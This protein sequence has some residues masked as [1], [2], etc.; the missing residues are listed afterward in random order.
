MINRNYR[1]SS[2]M[3]LIMI[4][5]VHSNANGSADSLL[6]KSQINK[7]ASAFTE[8][9]PASFIE[10]K[11]LSKVHDLI[12]GKAFGNELADSQYQDLGREAQAAVGVL[13][14]YHVPIRKFPKVLSNLPIGAFAMTGAIYVNE[15]QLM[16]ESYG[17]KQCALLC[18][19]VHKKYNDTSFSLMILFGSFMGSSITASYLMRNFNRLTRYPVVAAAALGGMYLATTSYS[20]FAERRADI[21]GHYAAACSRCVEESASRRQLIFGLENNPLKNS[22]CLNAADLEKIA[23]DLRAENKLC[24]HHGGNS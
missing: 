10:N 23:Q 11:I 17:A 15:D 21:E 4:S 7:T 6:E 24:S 14:E 5:I 2:S 20:R 3:L 16:S 22:G 9:K 12:I 19:A 1:N 8:S 13:K 18:A